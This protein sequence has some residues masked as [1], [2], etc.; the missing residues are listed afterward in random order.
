MARVRRSGRHAGMTRRELELDRTQGP[1][2]GPHR[3]PPR[4]VVHVPQK[5]PEKRMRYQFSLSDYNKLR[6]GAMEDVLA[7]FAK[8]D[9]IPDKYGVT[10]KSGPLSRGQIL[11]LDS[12]L[13]DEEF[14]WESW[15]GVDYIKE[16]MRE[17]N[18]TYRSEV[19][20]DAHRALTRLHSLP[21]ILIKFGYRELP[22]LT[23]IYKDLRPESFFPVWVKPV[24][25]NLNPMD[26]FK[27]IGDEWSR[28][29]FGSFAPLTFGWADPE[30][31]KSNALRRLEN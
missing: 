5:P 19:F 26:F 12:P 9:D 14:L 22:H 20:D 13:T 15:Q 29:T 6:K 8:L 7:S 16:K 4:P 1:L 31:I 21:I 10:L 11:R 24:Q 23:T 27:H 18:G 28:S 25:M 3:E 2:Y 17:V 30:V